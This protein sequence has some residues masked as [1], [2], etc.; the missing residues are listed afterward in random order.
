METQQFKTD[1]GPSLTV[2]VPSG[3]QVHEQVLYVNNWQARVP[4]IEALLEF[5][6]SSVVSHI[7]A[8]YEP[9][10]HVALSQGRVVNWVSSF[11]SDS[12]LSMLR[13]SGRI[14]IADRVSLL[15]EICK[16]DEEQALQHD[17]LSS[18]CYFFLGTPK[19]HLPSGISVSPDGIFVAEWISNDRALAMEFLNLDEIL[20]VRVDE[21][22]Q[23]SKK[24]KFT[25]AGSYLPCS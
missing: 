9:P 21:E 17:S 14:W 6:S 5:I 12:M 4:A 7:D 23:E 13:K 8:P 11:S 16:H 24:V 10:E 15:L 18:V 3:E 20:I 25:E 1:L 22:V 2:S 19:T